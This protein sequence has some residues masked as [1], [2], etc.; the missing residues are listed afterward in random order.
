MEQPETLVQVINRTSDLVIGTDDSHLG[1]A[2]PCAKWDVR[3]LINH[4]TITLR[5]STAIIDGREPAEDRLADDDVLG[6]DWRTAVTKASADAIASFQSPAAMERV[7]NGPVGE[8]PG[9]LWACFPTWDLHVHAWDLA[10]ATMRSLDWPAEITAPVQTWADQVFSGP[11]D[12][13]QLGESI[14]VPEGSAAIDR[15]VAAFGRDPLAWQLD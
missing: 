13:D 8:M 5:Y 4:M 2:T 10:A 6:T 7:V 9:G 12:V 11:R 14:T 1:R 15:L 3:S